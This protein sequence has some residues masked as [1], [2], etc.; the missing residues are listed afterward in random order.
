MSVKRIIRDMDKVYDA[1]NAAC[2]YITAYVLSKGDLDAKSI[3]NEFCNIEVLECN[4]LYYLALTTGHIGDS[5]VNVAVRRFNS[6]EYVKENYDAERE[7]RQQQ[8][9]RQ[10]D[11]VT[12]YPNCSTAAQ[13]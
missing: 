12:L 3:S 10:V 13:N 7:R 6:V 1:G 11:V 4:N 2:Q 5:E 9:Y 8:G